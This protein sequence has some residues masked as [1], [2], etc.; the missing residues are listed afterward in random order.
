MKRLFKQ[1]SLPGR[2]SQPCRARNAGL[3]PRRRRTGLFAVARLRRGLRQSR[4][5]RGL[6]RRRRRSRDRAAGDELAFEQVSQSGCATA[7]CCRSCI[8]T[9]TRSPI[10]PCSRASATRNCDQLFRGYGYTP[11]FVE[12]DEPETMHQLMAA[13]L[14]SVIAEIRRIQ[15]EARSDGVSRAPALADDRPAHA[16]GLDRSQGSRR[17][18][19]PKD[20]WRSHQVPMGDMRE[21]RARQDSRAVD[22]ELPAGGAVRREWPA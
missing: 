21:A 7:P 16:Q 17:Q 3:D 5:D 20:Y 15:A 11:Y 18:A 10:P 14:D 9:A 2:H 8:S 6:R 22:E 12:G 4:S 1:F 19:V 13:T